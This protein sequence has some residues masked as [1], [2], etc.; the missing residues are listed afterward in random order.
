M[1]HYGKTA[2]FRI[3]MYRWISAIAR[4]GGFRQQ[5][6]PLTGDFT[7]ADPSGYSPAALVY[8]DFVRRLSHHPTPRA[9]VKPPFRNAVFRRVVL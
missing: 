1:P 7:M 6:D 2:E 4:S 5:M 9:E 8:L 3:L